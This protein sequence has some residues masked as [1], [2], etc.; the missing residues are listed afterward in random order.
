[1]RGA[2]GQWGVVGDRVG[3]FARGVGA[4][5]L[6]VEVGV[7][8][9]LEIGTGEVRM[10]VTRPRLGRVRGRAFAWPVR[11]GWWRVRWRAVRALRS[12][13]TPSGDSPAAWRGRVG[14]RPSGQ[15][16]ST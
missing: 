11:A 16:H 13:D 8:G 14:Q 6:G 10:A 4:S 7:V 2:W 15:V 12:F 1:M 5:A 3:A 9:A